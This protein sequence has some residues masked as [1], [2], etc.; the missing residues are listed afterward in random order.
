M[1]KEDI[2]WYYKGIADAVRKTPIVGY[3][4]LVAVSL[5]KEFE[6]TINAVFC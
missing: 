4:N 6:D 2:E 1:F 3:S 5:F